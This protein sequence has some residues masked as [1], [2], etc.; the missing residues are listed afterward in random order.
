[1][2]KEKFINCPR[3]I[4]ALLNELSMQLDL[5]AS[6]NGNYDFANPFNNTG[7]QFN[8]AIFEV[9]AYDWNE[10]ENYTQEYNFKYKD[11]KIKWYKCLGRDTTINGNYS[12]ET[13]I[14]MFNKCIKSLEKI[15]YLS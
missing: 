9:N 7:G 2:K 5:C 12:Y 14:K 10:D 11:I 1:M 15:S 13:I 6:N 4:V 3:Y 8:N